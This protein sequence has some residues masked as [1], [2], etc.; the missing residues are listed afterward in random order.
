MPSPGMAA[1]LYS[2]MAQEAQTLSPLR[3][4]RQRPPGRCHNGRV[5]PLKAHPLALI[6]SLAPSLALPADAPRRVAP[7][8]WGAQHVAFSVSEQ[9]AAVEF[10][11][12]HG[13]IEGPLRLDRR[14]RFEAEG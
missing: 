3:G 12:A 2:R 5:R 11:C 6:V 13:R 7:G 9:G 10:D 4:E 8:D 1:I 14:G